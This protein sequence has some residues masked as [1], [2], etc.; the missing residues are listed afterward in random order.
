VCMGGKGLSK[1]LLSGLPIGTKL[2]CTCHS[3]HTLS[4]GSRSS[5][6][7]LASSE[8]LTQSSMEGTAFLSSLP[9]ST[10]HES[11]LPP[12][13]LKFPKLALYDRHREV[14]YTEL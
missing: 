4:I 9:S 13:P 1:I 8:V 7:I 10:E 14:M 5:E 2:P 6:L 12:L 3:K 11:S